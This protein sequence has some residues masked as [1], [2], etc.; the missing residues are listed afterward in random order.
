MKKIL[1]LGLLAAC[2]LT[3]GFT[4]RRVSS[5]I[6]AEAAKSI[7]L[8]HAGLTAE[9]VTFTR[10]RLDRENRTYVY[11]V[12]FYSDQKEYEYEI[13][14]YT[15]TIREYDL[16]RRYV[17][18]RQKMAFLYS[19][20]AVTVTTQPQKTS[21]TGSGITLAEAK[22]IALN[23]AGLAEGSVTF[24][25]AVRERDDGVYVYSLEFFSD[26]KEYEVDVRASDGKI[27]DYEAE[28]RFH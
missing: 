5:F 15:G 22:A 20:S 28:S 17:T 2:L 14:A 25:E 16:E 7:A 12:E 8:Q 21:Q 27:L 6:G 1:A 10:A 24:T 11:D 9:D 18:L 4:F 23:R 19:P 13:N 26:A 3:S